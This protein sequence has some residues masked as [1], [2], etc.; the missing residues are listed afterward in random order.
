M[1]VWTGEEQQGAS[2]DFS[3]HWILNGVLYR[4]KLGIIF[5]VNAE[6]WDYMEMKGSYILR[7]FED[8]LIN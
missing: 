7:L 3:P 8:F 6:V 5:Q 1:S 4:N 2:R